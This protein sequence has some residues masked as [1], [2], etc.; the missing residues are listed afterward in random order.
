MNPK[1]AFQSKFEVKSNKLKP[2]NIKKG[3]MFHEACMNKPYL[4][5]RVLDGNSMNN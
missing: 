5:K 2:M 1:L 3:E 4:I